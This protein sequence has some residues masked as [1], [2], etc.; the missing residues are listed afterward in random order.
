[1]LILNLAVTVLIFFLTIYVYLYPTRPLRF[2]RSLYRRISWGLTSLA[3]ARILNAL[4]LLGGEQ[5]RSSSILKA[6]TI[7]EFLGYSLGAVLLMLAAFKL[8]YRVNVSVQKRS[9]DYRWE[10]VHRAIP[11]I[12]RPDGN[13]DKSVGTFLAYLRHAF[14]YDA[15]SIHLLEDGNDFLKLWQSVG[16]EESWWH[17]HRQIPVKGSIAGAVI[18]RGRVITVEQLNTDPQLTKLLSPFGD[19]VSFFGCPLKFGEKSMG[20]FSIYGQEPRRFERI[21]VRTLVAAVDQLAT[22]LAFQEL[23]A[24]IS[25]K[26]RRDTMVAKLEEVAVRHS[27][28]RTA[29][30][31]IASILKEYIPCDYLCL[32]LL[33]RSGHNMWR[34]T[35]SAEGSNLIEKKFEAPEL[36]STLRAVI[37]EGQSRLLNDR[38]PHAEELKTLPFSSQAG[39]MML[40]PLPLQEASASGSRSLRGALICASKIPGD[41]GQQSLELL[42]TAAAYVTLIAQ[43]DLL[44]D[45]RETVD[46]GLRR[47][48]RRIASD[49][50]PPESTERFGQVAEAV[51]TS[52][53]TTSCRVMRFDSPSSSFK[54]LGSFH[55]Q[56]T[57]QEE[58]RLQP[59]PLRESPLLQRIM[60]SQRPMTVDTGPPDTLLTEKEHSKIFGADI[61]GGL[62][63][64]VTYEKEV[65]GLLTVGERRNPLRQPFSDD[66]LEFC[67][68]IANQLA[69]VLSRPLKEKV[70]EDRL[71]EV[72]VESLPDLIFQMRSPLTTILGNCELMSRVEDFATPEQ[73]KRFVRTVENSAK[74]LHRSLETL[75]SLHSS[76][77]APRKEKIYD[78][79]K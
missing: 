19:I 65:C 76:V 37:E 35:A 69:P 34:Y 23:S 14:G 43:K 38:R 58:S 41:F 48:S 15:I 12:L 70:G 10:L 71:L 1:V 8:W 51:V 75:S 74:K 25:T 52:L 63:L 26:E 57:G 3:A 31:G 22:V 18:D 20:V 9:D 56:A 29:L 6:S 72:V 62:I 50:P 61:K 67:E 40:S 78:L 77:R 45:Q 33:D 64:P 27:E 53:P 21:E 17:L 54:P 36:S 2:D 30:P 4:L 55:R 47:L 28:L 13:P 5:I 46:R 24:E 11:N 44:G 39:S 42:R 68:G 49:L 7:G 60:A 59:I 32:L 16:M 73:A 66:G 79:D